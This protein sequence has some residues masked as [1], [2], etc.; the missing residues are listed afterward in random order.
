MYDPVDEEIR[1]M[2]E[3]ESREKRI[4]TKAI[5]LSDPIKSIVSG[6]LVVMPVSS[7]LKEVIV[8]MQEKHECCVLLTDSDQL[9]GIFTEWDLLHKV[10]GRQLDWKNELVSAHMTKSPQT[11]QMND[12]IAYALNM[13]EDGGFRNVPLVDADNHP[14]GVIRMRD[15]VSYIA[16]YYHKDIMNLPPEPVRSSIKQHNG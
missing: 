3:N 6:Q 11:L 13:M 7:S 2:D 8:Q 15:I 12:H 16:H 1:I 10:A 14:A 9:A 4:L 5:D